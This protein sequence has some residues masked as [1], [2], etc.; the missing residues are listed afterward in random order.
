MTTIEQRNIDTLNRLR[1][2]LL[3]TKKWP[4][5]YMFKFIVPNSNDRVNAVV[6]TLPSGGQTS[7]K[8]SKDIHY[9]S[10][11]HVNYMRS[12]DEIIAAIERATAIE[13]VIS[14]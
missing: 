11:T 8:P 6:A 9:V 13:G 4:L 12:A 3:Q 10:V 1:N 2:V 14:L 5:K 7:F